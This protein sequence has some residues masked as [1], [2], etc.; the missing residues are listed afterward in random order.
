MY[1]EDLLSQCR[2]YKGGPEELD[3]AYKRRRQPDDYFIECFLG[4]WLYVKDGGQINKELEYMIPKV[5]DIHPE[6]PLALRLH[7]YHATEHFRHCLL[8]T[9]ERIL[10]IFKDDVMPYY[11]SHG[12][13]EE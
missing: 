13:P 8:K 9:P 12:N 1:P 4:E 6:I 10:E 3:N 7:L 2:F 11:L 5:S